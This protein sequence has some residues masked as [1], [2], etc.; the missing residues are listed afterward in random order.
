[1]TFQEILDKLQETNRQTTPRR[2]ISSTFPAGSQAK[3]R[4]SLSPCVPVP[5]LCRPE[6]S[7]V[8]APAGAGSGPSES[9]SQLPEAALAC[10]SR[11][12]VLS[13]FVSA[14]HCSE[15]SHWRPE[16]P[17]RSWGCRAALERLGCS[18]G[19][20]CLRHVTQSS[21]TLGSEPMVCPSGV[22]SVPGPALGHP[23]RPHQVRS[24]LESRRLRHPSSLIVGDVRGIPSRCNSRFRLCVGKT[25][26][27]RQ[28][29]HKIARLRF[30]KG[31]SLLPFWGRSRRLGAAMGWQAQLYPAF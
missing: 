10:G 4:K 15:P 11:H 29:R 31:D 12:L 13:V 25:E 23:S 30:P 24:L 27:G 21:A 7:L 1:M 17:E 19:W 3:S 9:H 14:F 20:V 2:I 6:A 26:S 28:E 18:A 8:P 16:P 5:A 22:F